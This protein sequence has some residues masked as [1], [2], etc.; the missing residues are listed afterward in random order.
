M[1]MYIPLAEV[2]LGQSLEKEGRIQCN[3][4]F[5]STPRAGRI[6]EVRRTGL[7]EKDREESEGG[8]E[9]EVRERVREESEGGSEGGE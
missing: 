3:Q 1:Y 5:S 2:T 8:S 7:K 4:Q 6:F 9:G